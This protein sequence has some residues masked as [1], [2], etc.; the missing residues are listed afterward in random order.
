MFCECGCGQ[1]TAVATKTDKRFGHKKDEPLRFINGHNPKRSRDVWDGNRLDSNGYV[2]ILM[3]DHS[4]AN[5]NGYV[6][7]HIL[8]LE[9]VLGRPILPTEATHHIDGDRTNNT[10]G[11]LMLFATNAMHISYHRRIDAFEACG[12]YDWRRCKFCHQYDAPKNIKIPKESGAFH[13]TCNALYQR[14]RRAAT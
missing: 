4:R 7:E 12:H 1:K 8:V 13:P 9:K 11:N 10:P 6:Q 14:Q 5:G 2:K 3:P